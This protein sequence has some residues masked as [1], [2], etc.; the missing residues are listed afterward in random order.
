MVAV[1]PQ[2]R[3]RYF[4]LATPEVAAM[5]ESIG[6]VSVAANMPGPKAP[7]ALVYARTCYNHLAGELA[8]RIYDELLTSGHIE[9]FED[10]LNLTASGEALLVSLG[11]DAD[12]LRKPSQATVRSCLDWTERRP[13]LAGRAAN[14]MLEALIQRGWL[15]RDHVARSIRVTDLGK[16][17]MFAFFDLSASASPAQASNLA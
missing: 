7:S 5:L 11:V 12:D 4:R 10:K 16:S 6:S 3:H 15:A 9:P 14:S 13:H 8:V 17:E 1:E 2:G